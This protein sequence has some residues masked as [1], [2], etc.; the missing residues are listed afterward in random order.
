MKA[1][2]VLIVLVTLAALAIAAGMAVAGPVE[3]Y[4]AACRVSTPH[5]IGSGCCYSVDQRTVAVI[6]CHHVVK[7]ERRVWVEFYRP[8]GKS[9]KIIGQVIVS[10]PDVDTAI[11]VIPSHVFKGI[12]P[13]A[14]PP[15]KHLPRVGSK[16]ATVGCPYGKDIQGYTATVVRYEGQDMI[17]SPAPAM[18]RSGSAVSDYAG[19]E[20]VA[21]LYAQQPPKH[22]TEGRAT[23]ITQI[24][25]V[26]DDQI[27]QTAFAFDS[28]VLEQEVVEIQCAGG[29]CAP[30]GNRIFGQRPQAQQPAVPWP[31]EEMPGPAYEDSAGLKDPLLPYRKREAAKDE[32]ISQ[33]LQGIRSELQG[34]KQQPTPAA[35]QVPSGPISDPVAQQMA[36]QALGQIGEL[37][38]RVTAIAEPLSNIKAKLEA[39]AEKGGIKGKIAQKILDAAEGEDGEAKG[40]LGLVQKVL[41]GKL[42][43]VALAIIAIFVIK[44]IKDKKTTGDPLFIEKVL[45]KVRGA[46]DKATDLLPA[47]ANIA[48]DAALDKLH[49][50][51]D[52]LAAK[53]AAP[54]KTP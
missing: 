13:K 41:H 15:A 40:E 50:K 26:V 29:Q 32:A 21:V 49:A 20:I 37:D 39:D 14:I 12:L 51:V 5:G 31:N 6:T 36:Q 47:P 18:G 34:L 33:G 3:F 16:V 43:W 27:R 2:I 7:G 22:P 53:V 30:Q 8:N 4:G 11:I 38:K 9:A 28:E 10:R 19:N 1:R 48:V 45:D 42:I 54:P 44:D 17:F 25:A 46:R 24:A 35:P 23:A 52:Q